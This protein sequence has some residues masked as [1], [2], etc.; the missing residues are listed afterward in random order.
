VKS[1]TGAIMSDNTERLLLAILFFGGIFVLN[2]LLW[3]W[4]RKQDELEAE[5]EKKS[6][7]L[8]NEW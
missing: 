4:R 8:N 7:H 1:A 2:R 6:A 3:R 5:D